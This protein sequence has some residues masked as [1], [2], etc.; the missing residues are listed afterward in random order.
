[1]TYLIS[2]VIPSYNRGNALSTTLAALVNQSLPSDQFEVLLVDDG[3]SDG[4]LQKVRELVLPYS[5]R[6]LSQVNQG[7]AAARNRGAAQ[8][9]G[10][11]LLFLDA[12]MIA[13][14]NLLFEHLNAH[15]QYP[16]VL[17][18]GRRDRWPELGSPNLVE[19]FDY[20]PDGLDPRLE[21]QPVT[22]MEA[23][24]CNLSMSRKTWDQLG[25]FDETFPPGSGYED[26]DLAYRAYLFGIGIT[27]SSS[28]LAYHNHVISLEQRCQQAFR[29]TASV[30]WLFCKHPELRGKID[31]LKNKE[32]MNWRR[33]RPKMILIKT[34]R[35]FIA[36]TP[37]LAILKSLLLLLDKVHA[38]EA[39]LRRV[40]WSLL[41]GFTVQGLRQGTREYGWQ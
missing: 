34:F 40:Y 13:S 25:G 28:A 30:P 35:L 4:T 1:M 26:L 20:A 41:G 23:W 14:P 7:A 6:I 3:S 24:T 17:V 9:Q 11:H 29:Y 10:K 21:R 19:R 39:W 5:L 27:F 37:L 12:D 2:V 15:A 36:S 33:D 32:P 18:L 8:A 38:P 16:E 31:Y 22:Y